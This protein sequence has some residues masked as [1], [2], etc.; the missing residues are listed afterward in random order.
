MHAWTTSHIATRCTDQPGEHCPGVWRAYGKKKIK[1]KKKNRRKRKRKKWHS[2]QPRTRGRESWFVGCRLAYIPGTVGAARVQGASRQTGTRSIS[3]P[4]LASACVFL[5]R[6]AGRGFPPPRIRPPERGCSGTQVSRFSPVRRTYELG[7]SLARGLEVPRGKRAPITRDTTSAMR[8]QES[9]TA[10]DRSPGRVVTRSFAARCGFKPRTSFPQPGETLDTIRR[11][12]AR[13]ELRNGVAGTA[14]VPGLR[15]L[16][17]SVRWRKTTRLLVASY[18]AAEH[19]IKCA[20]RETGSVGEQANLAERPLGGI[21]DRLIFRG[22]T[23]AEVEY[24]LE[25]P[26]FYFLVCARTH[27]CLH[28]WVSENYESSG[29]S[30]LLRISTFRR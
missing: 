17:P 11:G 8:H 5:P 10:I 1:Q 7:R 3:R 15:E 4:P 9:Y 20:Q 6:S 19:A 23:H 22:C 25:S 12:P 27:L 29:L 18:S 28:V 16:L 14:L 26:R 24:V 2:V 30:S 21:F 13:D